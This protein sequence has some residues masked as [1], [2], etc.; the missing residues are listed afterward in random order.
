VDPDARPPK[1]VR[2]GAIPADRI[3]EVVGEIDEGGD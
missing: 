1:I 2:A 3:R